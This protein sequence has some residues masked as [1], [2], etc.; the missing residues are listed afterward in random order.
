[1]TPQEIC[2]KQ[3]QKALV[4]QLD[5]NPMKGFIQY[6]PDRCRWMVVW[7]DEKANKK[8][9][10]T[11][12]NGE[13]M[14]CTAFIIKDGVP[15]LDEKGRLIPDKQKCKG[16]ERA[17]RL[18]VRIQDRYAESQK[19]TCKFNIEEFMGKYCLSVPKLYD[20]WIKEAIEGSSHKPATVKAYKSYQRT[21]IIPWFKKHSIPAHEVDLST[22]M[23][24]MKHIK[25]T[26]KKKN[27][28]D[29]ENKDSETEIEQ[30]KNFGK[31]A[32]NIMSALHSSMDYAHRNGELMAIPPFPKLKDYGIKKQKVEWLERKDLHEIFKKIP[33]QHLPIFNWIRLHFRRPGEACALY[34]T[35]YDVIRRSFT[36]QR[37]IS[38]RKLV[39]SVKTNWVSPTVHYIP[40]K[41]AFIPIAERLI[42]K[43]TDSPYM[44]VNPL[45]RKDGKR[46]SLESLRIIWY[47]ACDAAGVKRIWPYKGLKHTACTHFLEDGGTEIELQKL[48]GHV[49]MN[50]LKKYTDITLERVRK[51]QEDAEKR[52][53]AIK[54]I[55]ADTSIPEGSN[56][57]PLFKNKS[58]EN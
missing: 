43:D 38:A 1:M 13:F 39:G 49:N 10:I 37:S 33:F 47:N 2:I 3:L 27:S 40:C 26:L 14:P 55:A 57:V 25:K 20:T 28:P 24:L 48:T 58:G 54:R 22:T 31:T 32:L 50:S 41:K 45:A 19:G 30:E 17:E 44:F 51:V 52:E 18:L 42:N 53:E 12:D 35:D 21:W 34:K 6:Q 11:R 16:H 5:R 9:F 36:V 15:S 4:T 29:M 23:A 46:Y 56:V 8:R 7:W